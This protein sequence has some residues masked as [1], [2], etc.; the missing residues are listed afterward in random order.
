MHRRQFIT[1]LAAGAAALSGCSTAGSATAA[2]EA[3]PAPPAPPPA[4]T[5]PP[6]LP[7]PAAELRTTLSPGTLTALPGQGTSLALTVD[8]GTNSDVVAAYV[9][10]AK[11]T[12]ARFTFFVTAVY[13]SWTANRKELRPLVDS[14]QIQLANHTWDHPDLTKLSSAAVASQLQRT[15]DFLK[16]QYGVDGAPYF[17]PPYGFH[18]AAVDRVA[19]DLGYTVP[20]LW[21]G[22]LSDSQVITEDYLL[23]CARK[24]F[25]PQALVIGHANHP[26][27]THVYP[28]LVD[29]VKQRGLSMV[30][31]D[32]VLVRRR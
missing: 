11:D 3:P 28:Q 9:K 13:D 25:N 18:N 14:G 20:T 1:M 23:E 21:Y 27:V 17:R 19:A 15:R 31:L 30:T 22:S 26:P 7:P 24:Y 29:I 10:F 12:G 16:N 4:P 32:D 8:D 2:G 5:T 6:L